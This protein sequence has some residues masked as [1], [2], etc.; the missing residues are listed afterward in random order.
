MKILLLRLL[1]LAII[2]SACYEQEQILPS[3]VRRDTTSTASGIVATS[4]SLKIADSI[5]V[6]DSLAVK[7][8]LALVDSLTNSDTIKTHPPDSVQTQEQEEIAGLAEYGYA[9][10]GDLPYRILLPEDY[11]RSKQYPLLLF[12]HGIGERGRDNEQQLRWGASLFQDK[13]IREKYPAIIVFPQCRTSSY[14]FDRWGLEALKRL[15]DELV[16]EHSIDKNKIN[17][18]GLSMGAYGTYAMVGAHPDLFASAVAISG[19]GDE[20]DAVVMSHVRWR[21]YAGSRDNVVPAV[22]SEKMA[23]ALKQAGADVS[24]TLYPDA[25]HVTSWVNALAEADFCSWLFDH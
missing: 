13:N 22:K 4:D 19:D 23:N 16:D 3:L 17:I 11:D 21:I 5:T 12:L 9:K 2:V 8:S 7:D 10:S 15:I 20:K 14:W 24:F 1:F 18:A 6:V 25:D